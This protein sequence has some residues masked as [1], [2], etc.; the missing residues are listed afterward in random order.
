MKIYYYLIGFF[1][2]AQAVCAQNK[3]FYLSDEDLKGVWMGQVSDN[4]RND[5]AVSYVEYNFVSVRNKVVHGTSLIRFD[6]DYNE[7]QIE[8]FFENGSLIVTEL[9]TINKGGTNNWDWYLK[10]INFK[11]EKHETEVE[12][13]GTWKATGNLG[14]PSQGVISIRKMLRA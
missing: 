11:I 6:E 9:K 2:V 1:F 8:G 10:S 7:F 12:L 5:G 3:E 4:N 13:K 14:N